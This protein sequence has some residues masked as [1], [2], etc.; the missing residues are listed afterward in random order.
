MVCAFWN[1]RIAAQ[2]DSHAHVVLRDAIKLAIGGWRENCAAKVLRFVSALGSDVWADLPASTIT[3]H[4][5]ASW[6][7]QQELPVALIMCALPAAKHTAAWE[8]ARLSRAPLAFAT[9]Q[10]R[11]GIQVSKDKHYMGDGAE[12]TLPKHAK[13]FI[14]RAQPVLLMCFRLCCWPLSVNRPTEHGVQVPRDERICRLCTAGDEDKGRVGDEIHVLLACPA[15]EEGNADDVA[16]VVCSAQQD[17]LALLLSNIWETRA[18][19]LQSLESELRQLCL[20]VSG[21]RQP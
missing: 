15:Y 13:V 2:T 5:K 16:R 9:H 8:H 7:A 14:P 18:S 21:S 17:K 4:G 3:M 19:K 1:N 12:V 20:V 11:P 10:K 6:L